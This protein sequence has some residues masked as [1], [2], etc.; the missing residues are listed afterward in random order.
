MSL[1]E[2]PF[3]YRVTK[4]SEVRISRGGRVVLVL[5]GPRAQRL[6]ARLGTGEEADQQVLARVT[7]NYRHGNERRAGRTRT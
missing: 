2:D 4:A 3:A 5:G 6:L 7:G 1:T